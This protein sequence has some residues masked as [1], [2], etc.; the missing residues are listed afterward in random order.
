MKTI[1]DNAES[2]LQ[3]EMQYFNEQIKYQFT[4]RCK[5]NSDLF[6]LQSYALH[7]SKSNPGFFKWLFDDPEITFFGTSLS[8]DQKE[9][10]EA[11]LH[12]L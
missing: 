6:S 7:E 4:G 2:V 11:W 3:E 8:R 12:D 5:N 9:E 1:I 10:F